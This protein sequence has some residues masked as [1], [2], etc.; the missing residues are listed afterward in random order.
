MLETLRKLGEA[1]AELDGKTEAVDLLWEGL[2]SNYDREMTVVFNF[3]GEFQRVDA[4]EVPSSELPDFRFK[5]PHPRKALWTPVSKYSG[6]SQNVLV[7]LRKALSEANSWAEKRT[8]WAAKGK[9]LSQIE[10]ALETSEAQITAAIDEQVK[11]VADKDHRAFVTLRVDGATPPAVHKWPLFNVYIPEDRLEDEY[12]RSGKDTLVSASQSCTLCG[13]MEKTVFGN[14]AE[15]KSYHLDQP[16]QIAGGF[17]ASAGTRNLPVCNGCAAQTTYGKRIAEQ[18]LAFGMYGLSYWLL[19]AAG[20]PEVVQEFLELIR[21]QQGRGATLR[22]EALERLTGDE[23]EILYFLA[24]EYGDT[25]TVSLR[26]VVFLAQQA[27][28]RILEEI[29]EVLPSRLQ[30]IFAVKK[31]V[32]SFDSDLKGRINLGTV[33]EFTTQ[34]LKRGDTRVFL[35]YV[36]AIFH[37][38][39]IDERELLRRVVDEIISTYK[40]RPGEGKYVTLRGFGL[41]EFLRQLDVI[42]WTGEERMN[43]TSSP[44]KDRFADFVSAHPAHFGGRP[45]RAVAFLTGALVRALAR[46]QLEDRGQNTYDTHEAPAF[47]KLRGFRMSKERLRDLLAEA[48]MKLVAYRADGDYINSRLQQML[49]EQWITAEADWRL[50]EDEATFYFTLGLN[51]FDRIAFSKSEENED[52]A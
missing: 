17:S 28:W 19:P 29:D 48:K 49:S 2:P 14:Y 45:D 37:G 12:G 23:D 22:D 25:D 4:R 47:K 11:Q 10:E 52:N 15:L 44:P 9:L 13:E 43:A 46:V 50:T 7:R 27:Q 41:I 3:A 5:D 35:E 26:M 30:R 36:A 40:R 6:K 20:Q 31:R 34:A 38:G 33:R 32:E 21:T 18:E 39:R 42:T 16:G 8:E 1:A 24:E 51:L